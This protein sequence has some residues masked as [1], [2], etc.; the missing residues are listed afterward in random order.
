MTLDISM[1]LKKIFLL[2]LDCKHTTLA[3]SM[4]NNVFP[5]S[6]YTKCHNVNNSSTRKLLM[7]MNT[8]TLA[9]TGCDTLRP[10]N[11]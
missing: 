7:L 4:F 10:L 8:I 3:I 5:S 11:I 6:Y 9:I 2:Q 1:R